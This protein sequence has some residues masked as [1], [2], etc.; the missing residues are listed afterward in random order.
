MKKFDKKALMI[1][2]VLITTVIVVVMLIR[3]T[4]AF[5]V[6]LD[7]KP[8]G[9]VESQS[10]FMD[11]VERI[12]LSAES[13]YG[14]E[15]LV[16]S[17]IDYKEVY[18][19][20]S[21]RIIDAASE[22]LVSQVKES[23][24]LEARVFAINVGGRDIAWLRDKDSAEQVLERLKAPYKQNAGF[25]VVVDFAEN[26]S[27]KERIVP[28]DKLAELRK[29]DDVY[30][31]IVQENETIKKYVVQKGDTVSEI[32]QKLGVSIKDIKKA[33]PGLNVD[34]ISIGQELNLSVPRYVINVRQNKTMV[35]EDA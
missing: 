22:N 5:E 24:Q 30:S 29:P 17:R 34:R 9:V 25:S 6:F 7:D 15:M 21:N 33:N 23:V 10:A 8:I 27:I 12:K 11:L 3:S 31:S 19:P 32:A 13:R 28:N 26:V 35:Y 1:P 20:D 18:L 4:K 14:T 2:M 16:A